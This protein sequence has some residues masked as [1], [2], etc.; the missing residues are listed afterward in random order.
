MGVTLKF[1]LVFIV[2]IS[3]N[4]SSAQECGKQQ[5]AHQLI[6]GGNVVTEGE[7]PWI[8]SLFLR[9]T[10]E[11]FCSANLISHQHLLTGEYFKSKFVNNPILMANKSFLLLMT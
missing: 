7:W 1:Y 6:Y 8:A 11:F 9:A 2:I 10:N 5:S 4:Y 3:A